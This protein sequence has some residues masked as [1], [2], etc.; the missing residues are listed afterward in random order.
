MAPDTQPGYLF[1]SELYGRLVWFVR[2]RWGA[3]GGLAAA[4]F[5]G[6][7]M[8]FP[9]VWPSLLIVA[10][11]VGAANVVFTRALVL[12]SKREHPYERLRACA[13]RQIVLDLAALVVTAH[14]TG[15]LQSPALLFFAFHMAIGTI[16]LPTRIMYLLAACTSGA[17]F[18]LYV[19]ENAGV[20]AFHP[21]DPNRGM[22]GIACHYNMAAFVFALIGVVAMT[23]SVTSRFKK[24]N[25]ELWETSEE[26]RRR[27][28]E[29]QKTLEQVEIVEQRKSHYMRISAHQLRSPLATVRTS[30]Q[31]LTEG[32]VDP[33]T[34]RG[35]KLLHG[36]LERIDGLLAIVNDLLDLAKMRE[37]RARAPWSRDVNVNQLLADLFDALAPLAEDRGVRIIP[38][39]R[40][41][42]VLEWGVPPDLI[43]AFEN[44][45]ENAVKYSDENGEVT[46]GLTVEDTTARIE[47]EDHG[48]GIPEDFIDD[49][50]QEFVRAPNAKHHAPQGTGLGLAITRE[51]V[52]AHG[53]SLELR[54]REGEG[55]IVT[56]MLPLAVRPATPSERSLEAE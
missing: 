54:S 31:V 3:V 15:G 34:E 14:F 27:S 39:F 38:N 36:A 23:D 19:L 50:V 1:A 48:I 35:T 9:S 49:V 45:I 26:L 47:I 12:R 11:F 2:L 37:G 30:L 16:V 33:G 41:V 22:C 44:L 10:A 13:V 51:A 28:A 24:R 43:Y 42:A 29:L 21:L 17:M 46:V 18:G 5:A 40:G 8:G 4:S 7:V 20:L 53:G 55:T 56:V 52:E 6:P 32:Y 25:I